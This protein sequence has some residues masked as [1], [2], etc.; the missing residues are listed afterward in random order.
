MNLSPW[1]RL[2]F[3]FVLHQIF[4]ACCCSEN[5]NTLEKFVVLIHFTSNFLEVKVVFRLDVSVFS[6]HLTLI[7]NL[8]QRSN[9]DCVDPPGLTIAVYN[10]W[11]AIQVNRNISCATISLVPT[12]TVPS[13]NAFT[14]VSVTTTCDPNCTV[15]TNSDVFSASWF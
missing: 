7:I 13:V 10:I 1:A 3:S 14:S 4:F 5:V 11:V 12:N 8:I 6:I 15:C 9:M 2:R